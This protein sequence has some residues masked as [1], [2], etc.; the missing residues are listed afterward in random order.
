MKPVVT[1]IAT[2]TISP[3]K[4]ARQADITFKNKRLVNILISLFDLVSVNE[5]SKEPKNPDE[6]ENQF[7]QAAQQ[8]KF[9]S[10]R[11]GKRLALL[12]FL[13]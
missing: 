6:S 3:I 11:S 1:A 10:T 8:P 7:W 9:W 4:N 5:Q 12:A 2:I 13:Q